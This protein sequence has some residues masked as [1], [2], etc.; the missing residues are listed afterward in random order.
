MSLTPWK[1]QPAWEDVDVPSRSLPWPERRAAVLRELDVEN[2]PRYRAAVVDGKPK[3]FCNI[4][5]TDVIRNMGVKAPS[6][7]MTGKGE[8]AKV[9]QGIEM[10]AN[11]L[12]PWFQMN[13]ATYGWWEADEATAASAADR[14][15]LVV[16]VYRNPSGPGHIVIVKGGVDGETRVAQAGAHNFADT[17]LSTAFGKLPRKFWI[18]ADRESNED[19]HHT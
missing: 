3:T 4:F 1:N 18:Q 12:Y 9:G 13:G 2:A 5:V 15:H 10:T 16:A 8:P 11:R 14:G 7:W 17:S 19:R 6:H